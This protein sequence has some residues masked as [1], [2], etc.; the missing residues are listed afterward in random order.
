MLLRVRIKIQV[1]Q[2]DGHTA[3][4]QFEQGQDGLFYS[5]DAGENWKEIRKLPA[6]EFG[7]LIIGLRV[8][9]LNKEIVYMYSKQGLFRF[10]EATKP[11]GV[12]QKLSGKNGLPEGAVDGNLYLDPTG[13]KLIAAV[14]G[15]GIFTSDDAGLSWK[16]VYDWNNIVK[17]FV[18]EGFPGHIYATATRE[19]G[20]Q[21]RVSRDGGK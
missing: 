17:C 13:K 15:K 19:S 18:N 4:C 20:E 1:T 5:D 12:F 11:E 8:D 7:E 6:S 3:F 9:P 2:T 10:R 16:S 14:S 21:V